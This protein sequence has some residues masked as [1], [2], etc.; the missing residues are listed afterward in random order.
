MTT[1]FDDPSAELAWMFLQCLSEGSDVDECFELLS[2]DFS[3]WNIATRNSVD[4]AAWR[5]EVERRKS[6]VEVELDFIQCFNDGESVVIE[7]EAEGETVDGLH[8]SSPAVFIF[9]TRDGL[10]SSL[11]EYSDTQLTAHVFG[12]ANA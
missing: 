4:K 12:T 3:Y 10:I 11:R 5:D 9:H 8:Y 7:A 6:R 1:P 2:D